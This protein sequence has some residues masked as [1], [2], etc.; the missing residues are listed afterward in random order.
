MRNGTRLLPV[1]FPAWNN[2]AVAV[3]VL[4]GTGSGR[5]IYH[6]SDNGAEHV[7]KGPAVGWPAP[8]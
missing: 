7:Y 8:G 6:Y 5:L 3:F 4:E 2:A 1:R